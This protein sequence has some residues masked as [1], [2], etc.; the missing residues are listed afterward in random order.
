MYTA[1]EP[2]W[3]PEEKK[4]VSILL[5]ILYIV[6]INIILIFPREQRQDMDQVSMYHCVGDA[7]FKLTTH[8][9]EVIRLSFSCTL[10]LMAS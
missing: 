2:V 3:I 7:V 4:K 5:T 10:T 8:A 6:S 1:V 9:T